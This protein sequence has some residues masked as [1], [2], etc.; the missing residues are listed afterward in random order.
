ME[1][2]YHH[3]Y[4]EE[5]KILACVREGRMEEAANL[6]IYSEESICKRKELL[7]ITGEGSFIWNFPL[8]AINYST[9]TIYRFSSV[10][11]VLPSG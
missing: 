5:R 6:L 3:T 10:R 9:G 7:A 11:G 1:V 4:A 2:I 8:P